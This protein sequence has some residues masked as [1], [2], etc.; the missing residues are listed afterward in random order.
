M[1]FAKTTNNHLLD[2]RYMAFH[3]IMPVPK[4]TLLGDGLF[5]DVLGLEGIRMVSGEREGCMPLDLVYS[6]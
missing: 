1:S 6:T 4:Q 5:V 2:P 3:K